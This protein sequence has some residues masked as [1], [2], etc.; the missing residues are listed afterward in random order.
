MGGV[1]TNGIKSL[2][3]MI[4]F[5]HAHEGAFHKLPPKRLNHHVREFAGRHD[6]REKDAIDIM[7]VIA[8]DMCGKRLRFRGPI[9]LDRLSSGAR[10]A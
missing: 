2:W 3:V 10:S 4:E 6:R 9:A 8:I 1:R 5:E 7:G